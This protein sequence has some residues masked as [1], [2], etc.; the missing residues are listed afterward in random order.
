MIYLLAGLAEYIDDAIG[1]AGYTAFVY[2]L[3]FFFIS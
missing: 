1:L 3:P 2:L